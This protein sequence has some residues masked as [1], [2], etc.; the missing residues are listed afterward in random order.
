MTGLIVFLVAAVLLTWLV[1]GASYLKRKPA[2]LPDHY[3]AMLHSHVAY[4]RGLNAAE[5]QRFE[6]KISEFLSYVRI[7][8]VQTSVDNLDRLLVASSAVIPIFGFENWRYNNLRDVLLYDGAFDRETFSASYGQ[9]DTLGMVGTGA[10]QQV[11]ILSKPALRHGFMPHT[12][13]TNT[14]IHEFV[15]LLDKADGATDGI[16]EQL[17]EHPYTI[18]WINLMNDAI[19]AIRSGNSDIDPYGATSK[20]EFFAVAAEYFFEQPQMLQL[21]HPQLYDMLQQVFRQ[22]PVTTTGNPTG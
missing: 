15:H 13:A 17:L 8:G 2:I 9:R 14:G 22:H 7:H 19:Q 16:P 6:N 11:M 5:Q 21:R 10:L 4:Y 20:A 3:R 1:F 18:P 12:N